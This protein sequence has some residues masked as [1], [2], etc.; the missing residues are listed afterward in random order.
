MSEGLHSIEIIPQVEYLG[1]FPDDGVRAKARVVVHAGGFVE[2]F[3]VS[4]DGL[5]LV[6]NGEGAVV[7]SRT[8]LID[9]PE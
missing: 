6:F 4:W 3:E 7:E 9:E 5:E 2:E 1:P 8:G